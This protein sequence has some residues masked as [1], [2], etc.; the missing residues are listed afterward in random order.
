MVSWAAV[1]VQFL[2]NELNLNWPPSSRK[3]LNWIENFNSVLNCYTALVSIMAT[4]ATK[5]LEFFA[6]RQINDPSMVS[7]P[8]FKWLPYQIAKGRFDHWSRL[9]FAYI[10]TTDKKGCLWRVFAWF[11][12]HE[13]V[14]RKETW[15][16]Y[17]GI[18]GRGRGSTP[19]AGPLEVSDSEVSSRF[20]EWNLPTW[21]LS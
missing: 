18:L 8:S 9:F 1:Q 3:K 19:W 2:T 20:L 15:W 10:G 4:I 11:Q 16:P 13:N 14:I 7:F 21:H 6:V 5:K 12:V 17:L